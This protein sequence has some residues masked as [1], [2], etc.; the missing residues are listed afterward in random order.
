[1]RERSNPGSAHARV[2]GFCIRV[3]LRRVLF[4]TSTAERSVRPGSQIDIDRINVAH[5]ILVRAEGRHYLLLRSVDLLLARHDGRNEVAV[6]ERFQGI[7]QGW[8]IAGTE[9]VGPVALKAVGTV[10][11]ISDIGVPVDGAIIG[12]LEGRIAVLV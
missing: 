8:C 2:L 9:P 10:P 6:A 12:D 7:D 11:Q 3:R 4:R 1:M 5:H